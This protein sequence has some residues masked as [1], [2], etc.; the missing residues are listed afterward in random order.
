MPSVNKATVKILLQPV[1]DAKMRQ[2]A[3]PY[4]PMLL[5]TFL[6][7]WIVK[8]FDEIIKSAIHDKKIDN[9][10]MAKYGNED[11]IPFYKISKFDYFVAIF[12]VISDTYKINCYQTNNRTKINFFD[13]ENRKIDRE[14]LLV[15][16]FVEKTNRWKVRNYNIHYSLVHLRKLHLSDFQFTKVSISIT[17]DFQL[18]CLKKYL[19]RI[20]GA[21]WMI[22]CSGTISVMCQIKVRIPV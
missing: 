17:I 5:K 1:Y 10:H 19:L 9:I 12:L 15:C 7:V 4:W 18:I 2:I 22:M 13:N 3:G 6:V 11:K 8:R 21:L 14:I 16:N 20:C